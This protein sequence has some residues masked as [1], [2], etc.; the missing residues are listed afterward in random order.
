MKLNWGTGIA[1]SFIAF[2]LM[3]FYLVYVINRSNERLVTDRPYEEGLAHN[4]VMERQARSAVWKDKLRCTQEKEQLCVAFAQDPQAQGGNIIL[5]RPK[6]D[7]G[8]LQVGLDL[9]ADQQQCI[10]AQTLAKG[11]WR[12]VVKWQTSGQ[13]FE[14]QHEL[15]LQ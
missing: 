13:E 12:V 2:A 1:I 5:Y 8:N 11:R 10:P 3:I 15:Y 14:W 6:G 9:T 7:V 4:A